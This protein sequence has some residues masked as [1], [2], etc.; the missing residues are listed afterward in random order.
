MTQATAPA[1]PAEALENRHTIDARD[2]RNALGCFGTGVAVITTCTAE[3]RC[4]GLTVNSFASVS[5]DPPLALWSLVSHSPSLSAFQ[6]A[7]HFAVNVLASTQQQLAMRFA[8]PA[9]DKFEALAWRAGRGGAPILE[10]VVASFECRNANRYY[11]GDHVIF[12]GA[13][14]AYSYNGEPPL[15]FARGKFGAFAARD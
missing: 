4:V 2:L 5:L 7:S 15:L 11:G 10:G 13:I 1:T 8:R 9:P 12:L 3:G 14:E 6:E